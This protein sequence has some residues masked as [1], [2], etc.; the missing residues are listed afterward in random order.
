[1]VWAPQATHL[2]L[3][4]RWEFVIPVTGR[5]RVGI[6]GRPF[7]A[8]RTLHLVGQ[9]IVLHAV[10]RRFILSPEFWRR[11]AASVGPEAVPHLMELSCPNQTLS[12]KKNLGGKTSFSETPRWNFN[13]EQKCVLHLA[14]MTKHSIEEWGWN[15]DRSALNK[16][17]V[18]ENSRF[19]LNLD[20]EGD[21]V[22]HS[23]FIN[24]S[25]SVQFVSLSHTHTG[26]YIVHGQTGQ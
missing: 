17:N 4:W 22:L 16:R 15:C 12:V 21:D 1:M 26:Y 25:N 24:W 2:N 5:G 23:H 8:L 10:Q 7:I 9:F 6:S 11:M 20:T 13:K 19:S 14:F 18:V 3:I